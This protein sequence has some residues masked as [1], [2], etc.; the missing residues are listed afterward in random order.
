MVILAVIIVNNATEYLT[1]WRIMS[2]RWFE[3]HDDTQSI[4]LANST[5]L[6][7]LWGGVHFWQRYH[8]D[9]SCGLSLPSGDSRSLLL[10]FPALRMHNVEPGNNWNRVLWGFCFTFCSQIN[11]ILQDKLNYL[12]DLCYIRHWHYYSKNCW[13]ILLWFVSLKCTEI[14]DFTQGWC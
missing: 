14:W 1:L 13:S 10:L 2:V 5:N 9:T 3:K 11:V 12:R 8:G 7:A 6:V 4:S